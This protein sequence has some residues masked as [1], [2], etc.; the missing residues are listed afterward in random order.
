MLESPDP[1]TIELAE[2]RNCTEDDEQMLI[3][4]HELLLGDP[5]HTLDPPP[6]IPIRASG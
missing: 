4:E 6:D 3:I 1:R 5:D 2:L